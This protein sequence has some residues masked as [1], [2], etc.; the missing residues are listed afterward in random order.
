M[1][2][3]H[4]QFL[5]LSPLIALPIII[6]LLN[7]IRYRRVRWAAIDFL[8]TT[9]RRAVRRARLRQLLLMALRMLLLAAALGALAQPILRGGL[10]ALLGGGGQVAVALDASASMSA[11][12]AGGSAFERG[13]RLVA[14]ALK[15]LPR[16]TRASAGAFAVSYTSPFREPLRDRGAVASVVNDARL[17]AG[18]GNV[19]R[20]LRS[21]AAAL[22][23][24]GGGGAIWLLTDLQAADWHADDPG[25]WEQVRQALD[26][27][28]RPK[29]IIT[30]MDPGVDSNLSIADVGLSPSVLVE[31]DTPKLTAT[32]LLRAGAS[33]GAVANVGL[34]FDG[35]RVDTRSHEFAEPGKADVV[36][37]LPALS[38]GSHWGYL[39]LSP[40][41]RPGDD[42]YYFVVRTQGRGIPLLVV[43]GA[44]S[45]VPFESAADFVALAARPPDS[46]LADRSVFTIESV[47]ADEFPGTDLS[48]FAAVVLADVPRLS[49]EA[50]ASLAAYAAAGGLVA[51]F[52]GAHTDVAA[53]NASKFPG[54]PI[55]STIEADEEK[56]IRLG[57]V[58]QTSPVT[59]TL[60]AEGL[61]RVLVG[62][63]FR[64]DTASQPGEVLMQTER[65][66]PFLVRLQ[67]GKGKVYVF[68]VSA[69]SDFSNF[70]FTPPFLLTLHRA[71]SSHLIEGAAPL[72][73]P[74]F[75]EL[76]L[77]LP[78]GTHQMLTPDG[79][80]MPLLRPQEGDLIFDRTALAGVYRLVTGEALPESPDSAP[81]VAALNVPAAESALER[82]EPAAVHALLPDASV[83]FLRADGSAEPLAG[84]RGSHTAASSF[85]LAA[86]A[87]AFLL[88]EVLLAWSM[89]RASIAARHQARA[90]AEPLKA[91]S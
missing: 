69:Q 17:T 51:V 58:S 7:R 2:F 3:L 25:E 10:A 26:K 46:D 40:D 72:S 76:K 57:P 13:K 89:G 23:R 55:E 67:A 85:P 52:P 71:V 33:T 32:V 60:P 37:R 18:R 22:E 74:A 49:P 68:A 20:A 64:F 48:G 73:R 75:C 79:K 59:A 6:H 50:T 87:M 47:S 14:S 42:R 66:D 36:F 82:I 80:A 70:P 29:I 24:A 86:L 65:G 41:A 81:P 15:S 19:P 54:L 43:D 83:S 53:W 12:G 78:P 88:G 63:M 5:W 1:N 28:D 45:S 27:A 30:D 9:E 31:G 44:P 56:R 62:R 61:D 4:P 38:S 39:E 35:R 8:L 16:G 90:S 21:A 84:G 11:T 34:F 77:D 91:A